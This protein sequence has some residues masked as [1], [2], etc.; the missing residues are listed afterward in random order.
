MLA[1]LSIG[2]VLFRLGLTF[3]QPFFFAENSLGAVHKRRRQLGRGRGRKLV[4]ID[5][6]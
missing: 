2:F 5:D 6:G 1:P 3:P 4:K